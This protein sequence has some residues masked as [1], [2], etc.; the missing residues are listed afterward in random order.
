MHSLYI[1][2]LIQ[3]IHHFLILVF[4]L[5]LVIKN[6]HAIHHI[7]IDKM[8]YH[9]YSH[10]PYY[11]ILLSYLYSHSL[12]YIS[13]LIILYIV[14]DLLYSEILMYSHILLYSHS[15]LHTITYDHTYYH[16]VLL[17][18]NTIYL[19]SLYLSLNIHL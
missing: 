4:I 12:Y 18:S 16:Y 11:D 14:Y 1:I 13:S 3:I 2:I 8:N 6:V 17:N 19:Y 7:L 5:F 10:P 9:T 15:S